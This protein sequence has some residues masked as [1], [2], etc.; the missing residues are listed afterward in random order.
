ML[1]SLEVKLPNQF[2]V[3]LCLELLSHSITYETLTP[4]VYLFG[5]YSCIVVRSGFNFLALRDSENVFAKN[6]SLIF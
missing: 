5:F 2:F 4:F 6:L 3:D 1:F